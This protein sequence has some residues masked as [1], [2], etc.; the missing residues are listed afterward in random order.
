MKSLEEVKRAYIL[1]ALKM[2]GGN[3]THTAKAL[4]ISLRTLRVYLNCYRSMG[5]EV[6]PA[7]PPESFYFP[8]KVEE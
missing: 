3:R 4:R 2:H 8:T 6:T 7:P 5:Y 1:A